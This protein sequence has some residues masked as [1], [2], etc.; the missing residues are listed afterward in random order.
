MLVL[1]ALNV[2]QIDTG[3]TN[4]NSF[5]GNVESVEGAEILARSFPGGALRPDERDRP[6]PRARRTR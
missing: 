6:R 4:S 2:T 3:L 1:L 5:R